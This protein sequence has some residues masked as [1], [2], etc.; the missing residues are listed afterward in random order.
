VLRFLTDRRV[1]FDNN[2]AARDIR[3]PTL[4][5][6]VPGCS[7]LGENFEISANEKPKTQY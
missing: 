1:P 2:A 7:V 3:M 5:Q 6:K 4:K